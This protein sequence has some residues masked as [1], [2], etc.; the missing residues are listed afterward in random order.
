MSLADELRSSVLPMTGE[1]V[2][3]ALVLPPVLGRTERYVV[4]REDTIAH[5][6]DPRLPEVLAT[7]SS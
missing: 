4:R 6:V 3:S 5:R 2:T 1:T 7:L